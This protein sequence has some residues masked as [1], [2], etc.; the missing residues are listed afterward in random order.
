MSFGLGLCHSK[1]IVVIL[2]LRPL[3]RA[4]LGEHKQRDEEQW[5][6]GNSTCEPNQREYCH[7]PSPN[8]MI[9]LFFLDEC[10]KYFYWNKVDLND[11]N[12]GLHPLYIVYRIC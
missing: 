5:K 6:Y 9:L 10:K 11:L 3:Y 12:Q 8:D 4:F 1:K 2:T 7:Y